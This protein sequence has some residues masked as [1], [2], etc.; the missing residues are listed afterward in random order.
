M[1]SKEIK[2]EN[3]CEMESNNVVNQKR[4]KSDQMNV[5]EESEERA[6]LVS[7][8]DD[9]SKMIFKLSSNIKN[10]LISS[11][12]NFTIFFLN[13]NELIK[14]KLKEENN[15]LISML[16]NL[17]PKF[18]EEEEEVRKKCMKTEYNQSNDSKSVLELDNK[19]KMQI[20]N[21]LNDNQNFIIHYLNKM[22]QDDKIEIIRKNTVLIN[23]LSNLGS[24]LTERK[25]E[26]NEFNASINR[27]NKNLVNS[28]KEASVNG[29][30]LIIHLKNKFLIKIYFKIN[31]S[32]CNREKTK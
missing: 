28:T 10:K 30:N 17:E 32:Q 26:S 23:K 8:I 4:T 25:V 16:F 11:F 15:E 3:I 24:N 13:P 29:K 19:F 20:L 9:P 5:S 27:I 7:I 14:E 1:S 21:N 22:N 6:N 31:S 18:E 2:R 12:N